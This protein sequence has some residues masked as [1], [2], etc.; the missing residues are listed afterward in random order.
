[1]KPLFGKRN[2]KNENLLKSIKRLLLKQFETNL[3]WNTIPHCLSL[4]GYMIGPQWTKKKVNY[5]MKNPTKLLF[6]GS[7]I[8]IEKI[9]KGNDQLVTLLQNSHAH[10]PKFHFPTSIHFQF[11]NKSHFH[12]LT[13]WAM[14]YLHSLKRFQSI[15][16]I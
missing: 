5:N 7:T 9:R 1:M 10:P 8:I 16:N 12:Y 4:Y 15:F 11:K 14:S 2:W 6:F 13:L 3:F